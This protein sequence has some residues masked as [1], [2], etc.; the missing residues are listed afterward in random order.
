[1]EPEAIKTGSNRGLSGQRGLHYP[2]PPADNPAKVVGA[3]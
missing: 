3:P 1:M 2:Q